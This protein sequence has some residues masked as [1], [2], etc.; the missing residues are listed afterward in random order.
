MRK[1]SARGRKFI[2][3]PEE[4]N[5]VTNGGIVIPKTALDRERQASMYGIVV[6]IG[7]N[8]WDDIGDGSK[9]AKIGD[10]VVYA[11]YAG[12]DIKFEGEDYRVLLDE[13]LIA[14]VIDGG[15]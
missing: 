1:L 15:K 7:E 10:K 8:C 3:K 5:E 14:V 2:V 11:K 13:D 6:D 4:I 12:V 9:Q